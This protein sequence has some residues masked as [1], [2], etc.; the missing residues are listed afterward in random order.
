MSH[1]RRGRVGTCQLPAL[2]ISGSSVAIPTGLRIPSL[3]L[4]NPS[5]FATTTRVIPED[6]DTQTIQDAIS[7][8]IQQAV[9][10]SLV[11]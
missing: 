11:I 2:R 4:K 3:A 9:S 1:Q 5:F 7:S 6:I 10:N 8:T